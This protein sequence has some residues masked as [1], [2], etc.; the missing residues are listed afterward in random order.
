MEETLMFLVNLVEDLKKTIKLKDNT[1]DSLIERYEK[2]QEE[3][4]KSQEL[5]W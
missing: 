1:Y 4:I 5:P 2:L 3:L